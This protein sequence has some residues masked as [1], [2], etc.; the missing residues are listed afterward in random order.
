MPYLNKVQLL[1]KINLIPDNATIEMIG[2]MTEPLNDNSLQGVTFGSASNMIRSNPRIN[3]EYI[4]RW[5]AC[6]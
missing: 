2:V 6:C 5:E 4:I 1:D 3:G